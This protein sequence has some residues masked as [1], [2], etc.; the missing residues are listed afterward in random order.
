MNLLVLILGIF[1]T[2][3]GWWQLDHFLAP[4]VWEKEGELIEIAVFPFIGKI[5]MTEFYTTCFWSMFFGWILTMIWLA[6]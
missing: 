5:K 2:V 4:L 3:L 6:L 1:F